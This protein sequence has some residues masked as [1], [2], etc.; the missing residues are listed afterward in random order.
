MKERIIS[1][2]F[3]EKE[4][5]FEKIDKQLYLNA[6]E[7]AKHFKTSKGNPKDLNEWLSSKATKEYLT[8]MRK[9]VTPEKFGRLVITVNSGAISERGTWIHKKL[10]IFFARWLSPDFAVWCDLQIEDILNLKVVPKNSDSKD[11][12]LKRMLSDIQIIRSTFALKP[13]EMLMLQKFNPENS[14]IDRLGI[15]LSDI[16]LLPTELGKLIGKSAI[17]VNML[18]S[19]K[20]YQVKINGVWQL[21]EKGREFG[22]EV[23]GKFQQIKWRVG[24][25]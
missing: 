18:L 9:I 15:S 2:V 20:G 7:T 14:P 1:K 25:L 17:E 19:Q 23:H 13:F 22:L 12:D 24:A 8:A 10:I 5:F 6:T 3:Q 16:Y 11:I 4:I 21:T